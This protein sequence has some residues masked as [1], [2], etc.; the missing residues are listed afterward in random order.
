[1]EMECA[2]KALPFPPV[3]GHSQSFEAHVRAR[4]VLGERGGMPLPAAENSTGKVWGASA[5]SN[6]AEPPEQQ[7]K[8]CSIFASYSS[9]WAPESILLDYLLKILDAPKDTRAVYF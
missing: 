7:V 2:F 1:M 3:A 9:F 5:W 8:N 6:F 4:A